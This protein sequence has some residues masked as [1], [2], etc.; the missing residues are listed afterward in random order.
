M[1]CKSELPEHIV[2]DVPVSALLHAERQNRYG[3][4][5]GLDDDE[6]A[7]PAE[8]ERQVVLQEWGPI[9]ALPVR[10][11]P[12]GVRPAIDEEGRV[13]W[14]AFG[15]VDFSRV[16]PDFDK[17]RYK[18]D[19]LRE[20][21]RNVLIMFSIVK[22]RL[23]GKAK[24]LVL[25]YLRMGVIDEE[26][27]VSWDMWALAELDRRARYLQQRIDELREVSKA[28]REREAEALLA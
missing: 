21:L 22:E 13:D 3:S 16:R 19:K 1:Q 9:L 14:G 11:E 27:I 20:E 2:A 5:P 24:Y 26:D 18:A 4:V 17:A 8:L 6:L 15:T 23:P 28:K 25:K 7:E 10:Y 12:R